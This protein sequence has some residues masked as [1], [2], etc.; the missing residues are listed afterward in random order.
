MR[1]GR[2]EDMKMFRPVLDLLTEIRAPVNELLR[3]QA[4]RLSSKLVPQGEVKDV[5]GLPIRIQPVFPMTVNPVTR[6]PSQP[7]TDSTSALQKTCSLLFLGSLGSLTFQQTACLRAL[8]CPSEHV[9]QC[10]A[11]REEQKTQFAFVN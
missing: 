5:E 3:P 6:P 10:Q 8:K 4:H 7:N 2:T 1:I 9:R 11:E